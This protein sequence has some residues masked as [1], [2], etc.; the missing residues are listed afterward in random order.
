[1][2]ALEQILE[3]TNE[4]E[5]CIA[6]VAWQSMRGLLADDRHAELA[7]ISRELRLV[8]MVPRHW[9]RL[10]EETDVPRLVAGL[11]AKP[12]HA[13]ELMGVLDRAFAIDLEANKVP[14]R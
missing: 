6:L 5:D 12:F 11:I 3:P 4:A 10:L 7:Q 2:D 9:W 14:T 1:V 13:D 8:V